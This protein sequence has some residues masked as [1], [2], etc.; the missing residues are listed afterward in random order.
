M[1]P[2]SSR[3]RRVGIVDVAAHAGVSRQTV[4]NVLNE[5]RGNVSTDT[6]DR[7]LAAM[8][9]LGYQ[10]NRAAQNLRSRRSMQIGYHMFGE[11]MQS[12]NGFFVHFVQA[13]VRQAARDNYQV[14]VFTHQD[15]PLRTF[16]ELIAQRNIDAFVLSESAVDD[17]RVRLLAENGIPFACMGR[18]ASD[19]PQQWVDVDNTAG[20]RALVGHLLERGHRSFAYAGAPGGEYW[21]A[22]RFTG[23]AEGL[24]AHGIRVPDRNVCHGP[25]RGVR[26]FTRRLLTRTAPPDVIVCGSDAVAAVVMHVAHAMGRAVGKDVAVTGFDGG[27]IGTFTEPALTSVRIPVERIARELVQRCRREIDHGPTGEPGLL[28]PTELLHGASA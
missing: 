14:V 8:A 16:R 18:L 27:A 6:Y 10:P 5:R 3:A 23:F 19:L 7:V 15:D 12:V 1:Q 9:A 4:S 24:A 17:P 22:E 11:Q 21:K 28:V 2:G 13:L 26:A 20:M 25:D